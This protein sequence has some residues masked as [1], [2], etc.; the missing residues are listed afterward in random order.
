MLEIL[1]A[2]LFV[3]VAAGSV[4]LGLRYGAAR[5]RALERLVGE[6]ELVMPVIPS[7]ATIWRELVN[8]IGSAIPASQK[9][10]PGLKKRLV[11]AGI[12]APGAVRLFQGARA[13][14]MAVFTL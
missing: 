6:R 5:A 8:R 9:D 7:A 11:R 12:R 10:L 14:A 2:V 3:L 13:V 4:V 1:T